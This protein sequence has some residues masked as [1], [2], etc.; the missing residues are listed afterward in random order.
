MHTPHISIRRGAL[1]L[2]FVVAA[3]GCAAE[4]NEADLG[5]SPLISQSTAVPVDESADANE[6]IEPEVLGTVVENEDPIVA[7]SAEAAVDGDSAI[8]GSEEDALTGDTTEADSPTGN[9]AI[10]G[11]PVGL[12]LRSGPGV[13]NAVVVAVEKNRI[14]TATGEQS[15]SWIEVEL[16]GLTGWMAADYLEATDLTDTPPATLDAN[17]LA[18]GIEAQPAPAAADAAPIGVRNLIVTNVVDGVNL[19]QDPT[20]DSQVMVGAPVN[21]VVTATGRVTGDWVEVTFDGITGWTLGKF[22][23]EA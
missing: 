11:V 8:D 14:V 19:R 20:A 23:A 2:V 18:E 3:S 4:S 17:T 10:V 12:N 15:G 9:F 1:A 21:S 22:L 16:D 13:E 7:E 6:A 5:Q